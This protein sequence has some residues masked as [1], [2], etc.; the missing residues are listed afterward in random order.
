[1]FR[2]ALKGFSFA[3]MLSICVGS[4]VF[5][6]TVDDP[7]GVSGVF[8]LLEYG[9]QPLSFI[10]AMYWLKDSTERRMEEARRHTETVRELKRSHKE[11][12]LKLYNE[13]AQ[14]TQKLFEL[15]QEK[16]S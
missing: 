2:L 1:M 7:S 3:I 12:I 10:L 6:E 15:I 13:H 8:K 16:K 14:I 11:E 5:S 4:V 9:G